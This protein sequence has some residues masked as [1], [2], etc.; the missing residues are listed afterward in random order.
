MKGFVNIQVNEQGTAVDC[1]LEEVSLLGKFRLMHDLATSL[2]MDASDMDL[3]FLIEQMGVLNDSSKVTH[4][5]SSKELSEMFD[6]M[7][8]QN[9]S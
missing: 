2:E 6:N 5:E 8:E 4:C 3:Y 1:T 9:E 7:E